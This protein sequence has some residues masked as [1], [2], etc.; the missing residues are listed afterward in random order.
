MPLKFP[1]ESNAANKTARTIV[2]IITITIIRIEF[3]IA[4]RKFLSSISFTK[5]LNPTKLYLFVIPPMRYKDIR[6]TL[7][8]GINIKIVARITAGARQMNINLLCA[9]SLFI[10]FLLHTAVF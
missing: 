7:I 9:F 6:K 8:V 2:Q 3:C 1:L 10:D 4:S 5:L